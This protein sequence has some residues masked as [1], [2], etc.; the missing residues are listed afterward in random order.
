MKNK[1]NETVNRRLLWLLFLFFFFLVKT[2]IGCEDSEGSSPYQEAL[3]YDIVDGDTVKV[4]INDQTYKLRLILVNTPETV[5]PN[6][7]VEF[8]GKEASKF[9]EEQLLDKTV[10]LEKDVSE[11][12]RYGRLLRYVWLE[13]PSEEPTD[14]EIYQYCF[15]SILLEK[16]YAKLSTHPPDVKYL[17]QFKTRN[18]I[19]R[20]NKAGLYKKSYRGD[21]NP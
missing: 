10:Y 19:A 1:K 5:H 20:Q 17:K 16:G 18:R 3:V 21:S 7:N 12:D 4:K 9:T 2:F 15:N 6:K 14:K 13:L 8:Y 11:T